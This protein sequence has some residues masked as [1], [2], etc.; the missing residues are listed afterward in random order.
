[1]ADLRLA[2]M[3]PADSRTPWITR[4]ACS[5]LMLPHQHFEYLPSGRRY[6]SRRGMPGLTGERFDEE[7]HAEDPE[8]VRQV[9]Q[10]HLLP[11]EVKLSATLGGHSSAPRQRP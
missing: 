7:R 11:I 5:P 4:R 8:S 6:G 1:M 9:C 10:R 3:S 2:S